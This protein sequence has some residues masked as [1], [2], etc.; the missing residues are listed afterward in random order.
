MLVKQSPGISD[1]LGRGVRVPA[2]LSLFRAP[3]G[4]SKVT[5]ARTPPLLMT[6]IFGEGEAGV[7]YS[8]C[9]MLA[10]LRRNPFSPLLDLVIT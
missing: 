6:S 8:E 9:P 10:R 7:V 3:T 2:G 1:C 4:K 5:P